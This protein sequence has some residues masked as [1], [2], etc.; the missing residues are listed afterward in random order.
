MRALL[1]RLPSATSRA[2]G[3][4][5]VAGNDV[6]ALNREALQ[7]FR[8]RHIA[9]VGQDP[10]SALNPLLR[11]R[12]LLREVAPDAATATLVDTLALVGL[13]PEYLRRRPGELSGDS[14]VESPSPGR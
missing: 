6:F 5:S 10:G 3:S 7:R 2:T 12:V 4:V 8:R 11:V 13:S 1:G 14:S 9:Y